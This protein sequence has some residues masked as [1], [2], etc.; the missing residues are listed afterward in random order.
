MHNILDQVP[1]IPYIPF[2]TAVTP[3]TM[4]LQSTG[5]HDA[6]KDI[7]EEHLETINWVIECDEDDQFNIDYLFKPPACVAVSYEERRAEVAWWYNEYIESLSPENRTNNSWFGLVGYLF[8]TFL[9]EYMDSIKANATY[10]TNRYK[11]YVKARSNDKAGLDQII[12]FAPNQAVFQFGLLCRMVTDHYCNSNSN[13]NAAVI[14][15]EQFADILIQVVKFAFT[16]ASYVSIC[17]LA[18]KRYKNCNIDGCKAL[19]EK[20]LVDPNVGE[21]ASFSYVPK[22]VNEN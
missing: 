20:I 19:M 7:F 12:S 18:L 6:V 14:T 8:E 4:S 22:D 16:A 15:G 13:N 11:R 17:D 5:L 21:L 2:A 9:P 10:Y 1:P 3:F